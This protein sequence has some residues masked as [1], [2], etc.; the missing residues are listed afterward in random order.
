MIETVLAGMRIDKWLWAARFFKTRSLASQAVEGGKVK[1]N[2]VRVKPAREVRP[3]DR[4]AIQIG[5]FVWE[6]TVLGLSSQRGPA[7]Q[8]RSLY[9]E[10]EASQSRR[11]EQAEARRMVA[12]PA[13]DLKGRPAKRDRRMIHRF[14][15]QD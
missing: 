11:R 1:V 15:H 3:G 8:A 14:T 6:I 13:A 7:E 5:E 2:E 4:L 12:E 10:S 9:A